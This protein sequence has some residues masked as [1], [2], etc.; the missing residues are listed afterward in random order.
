MGHP[1]LGPGVYSVCRRA[2]RNGVRQGKR[3]TREF[4][5][6]ETVIRMQLAVDRRES[7]E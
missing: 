4:V 1:A 6:M 7:S 5:T 3:L 2:V